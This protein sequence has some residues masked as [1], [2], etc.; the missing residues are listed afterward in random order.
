M[1]IAVIKRSVGGRAA[2]AAG[3]SLWIWIGFYVSRPLSLHFVD[4]RSSSSR[5]TKNAL[6]LQYLT[7]HLIRRIVVG[8]QVRWTRA[9]EWKTAA[10]KRWELNNYC[11][12]EKFVSVA[13]F[14]SWVETTTVVQRIAM[15][16][17]WMSIVLEFRWLLKSTLS[18]GGTVQKE[19]KRRVSLTW[20][21][22]GSKCCN[23]G[24]HSYMCVWRRVTIYWCTRKQKRSVKWINLVEFNWCESR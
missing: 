6:P 20:W 10:G 17:I 19:A 12:K 14:G 3:Q 5:I 15:E 1:F 16:W 24:T 21:T 13:A 23:F 2:A 11:V 7:G 22:V 18:Q 4:H 8:P 9:N